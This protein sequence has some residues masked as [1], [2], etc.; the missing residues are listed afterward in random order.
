MRV[1]SDKTPVIGTRNFSIDKDN[2]YV[3]DNAISK[4][5]A[6]ELMFLMACSCRKDEYEQLLMHGAT[7]Y[8]ERFEGKVPT[9]FYEQKLKCVDSELE[10]MLTRLKTTED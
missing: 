1:D 7:L 6:A 5:V 4:D 9:A 8:L 2:V 3:A 10:A